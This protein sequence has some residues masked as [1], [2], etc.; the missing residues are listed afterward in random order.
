MGGIFVIEPARLLRHRAGEDVVDGFKHGGRGAE[1]LA[2]RERE[3]EFLG[4]LQKVLRTAAAEG[5]DRLLRVA[6][7]EDFLPARKAQKLFLHEVDVLI[8][9]HE[10]IAVFLPDG[11]ADI[12]VPQH[13]QGAVFEVVIVE[14]AR[15]P[16]ERLKTGAVGK[17]ER[18]ER[19][20]T[21]GSVL[22][23]EALRLLA[24]EGAQLLFELLKGFRD[25][26]EPQYAVELLP[27]K[28]GR[29]RGVGQAFARKLFG[30]RGGSEQPVRLRKGGKLR[31]KRAHQLFRRLIARKGGRKRRKLA[32]KE[33][34]AAP[35]ARPDGGDELLKGEPARFPEARFGV[36]GV[37]RGGVHLKDE[38][39]E[40]PVAL[41]AEIEGKQGAE[42]LPAAF[43]GFVEGL[44]EGAGGIGF[45]LRVVLPRDAEG[46]VDALHIEIGAHE[47][48]A[49]DVHGADIG[50]GKRRKLLFEAGAR[51]LF[52][53]LSHRF[54]E[55]RAQFFAHLRRRL[56]RI[57]DGEHFPHVRAAHD[58]GDEAFDH[59]EGLAAPRRSGDDD[60]AARRYRGLLFG[61]RSR[62]HSSP[63]SF[64]TM[65]AISPHLT[66]LSLR[67]SPVKPHSE[68]NLQY[69]HAPL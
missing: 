22:V 33:A 16:F 48:G 17:G 60:L 55:R 12:L 68:R 11:G 23:A 31:K 13:M 42:L 26:F 34:D 61:C 4:L 30:A 62:A 46:G 40:R 44:I 32:R 65:R 18:G 25:R 53:R 29:G 56:P 35:D 69:L 14:D 36:G 58:E 63:L 54:D 9:V 27:R 66:A 52:P 20:G 57:G 28:L 24:F 37:L 21:G 8:F 64:L 19:A 2:Q 43:V 7:E 6:D 51:A 39:A 38:P 41:F 5:I 49:E 1:A 50:K 15:L 45:P 67:S 3:G 10:H 47:A 59:D